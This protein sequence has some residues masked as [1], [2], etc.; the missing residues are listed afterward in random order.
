MSTCT[1]G[2]HFPSPPDHAPLRRGFSFL[3]VASYLSPSQ[4]PIQRTRPMIWMGW[5]L[6]SMRLGLAQLWSPA[7]L[8]ARKYTMSSMISQRLTWYSL[9]PAPGVW[10]DLERLVRERRGELDALLQPA[11]PH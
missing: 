4:L 1:E 10:I 3:A 6:L 8:S 7:G 2:S 9:P 11:V 5:R